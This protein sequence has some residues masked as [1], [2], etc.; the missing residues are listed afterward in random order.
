MTRKFWNQKD[1]APWDPDLPSPGK[2]GVAPNRKI[3]KRWTTGVDKSPKYAE[4]DCG[5]KLRI[6]KT[7]PWEEGAL[8]PCPVCPA[9]GKR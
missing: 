3:V 1:Q 6:T 2:R 7:F 8:I 4:L 5:H 9:I